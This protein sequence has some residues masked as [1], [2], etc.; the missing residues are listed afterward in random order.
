M[1]PGSAVES[2]HLL[3]DLAARAEQLRQEQERHQQRAQAL[4]V[5][6]E[7]AE[8]ACGRMTQEMLD[9]QEMI[10][11][12]NQKVIET[13]Q[14]ITTRKRHIKEDEEE[15]SRELKFKEDRMEEI[16]LLVSRMNAVSLQMTT[17][18]SMGGMAYS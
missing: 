4:R 1:T 11:R 8:L 13:R 15:L 3:G 18:I 17:D 9:A 14:A 16:M 12:W 5:Q 2:V 6:I 10:R 7:Q